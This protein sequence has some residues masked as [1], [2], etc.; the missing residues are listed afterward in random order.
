MAILLTN[1]ANHTIPNAIVTVANAH[2]S[3]I[4]SLSGLDVGLDDW[5]SSSIT[6]TLKAISAINPAIILI[7]VSGTRGFLFGTD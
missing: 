7:A 3:M 6:K 4:Q 1:L 5:V 2:F